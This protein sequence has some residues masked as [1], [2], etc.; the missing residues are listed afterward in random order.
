ML[1]KALIAPAHPELAETRSFPRRG[2]R[3]GK[4]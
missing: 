3:Q 4:A 1:K 2:R